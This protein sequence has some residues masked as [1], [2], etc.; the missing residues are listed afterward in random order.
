[1]LGKSE[2]GRRGQQRMRWLNGITESIDMSLSKL[3]K[4]VKDRKAWLAA[5]HEV[6]KRHDLATK[7][8]QTC[9][10]H[11]TGAHLEILQSGLC[12]WSGSVGRWL[13]GS[14]RAESVDCCFIANNHSLQF[15]CSVMSVSLRPHGLQHTRLPCS[16]PTPRT[17]SNSC[18]L[19]Q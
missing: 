16:S 8:Q 13:W 2:G 5:D 1:M 15:S 14:M 17:C 10:S 11:G 6:A 7:K 4:M 3:E 19:S 12:Q 18:P 9:E